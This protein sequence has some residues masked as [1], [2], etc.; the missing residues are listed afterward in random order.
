M[1]KQEMLLSE[2]LKWR[3]FINQTTLENIERLD[4][5]KF[6]FYLG[7]DPSASSMTVGNLSILMMVK[8]FINAGHTCFLLA[9]GATGMIGDPDG[10]KEE[11][12]LLSLN[13]INQNKKNIKNQ[14]KKILEGKKFKL[15]DNFDWFKKI[16]YLDFLREVGKN[17]PMSKMLNREFIKE[18]IADENSG[19]SYAEFSYSLIQGYDF[20]YLNKKFGVNLQIAGSDQWGNCIAGV[21]L[22]RRIN[23]KEADI[24]T[25]PLII[26]KK[27]GKK[28]GK[29]EGGAIWL[30]EK[31]T[32]VYKF[33]QFWL[34][35][36]D[37]GVIDY[38]KIYTLFSK[39]EIENL[40]KDLKENPHLR[41]AQKV[42]ALEIT[43]IV[44]GKEKAEMAKNITEILFSGDF[45]K[46]NKK[47]I[48]VLKK[49][50]SF[51][52]FKK[53]KNKDIDLAQIAL[54]LK[55]VQSKSE[56]R[57]FIEQKGLTLNEVG[58]NNFKIIKKG[59][60]NFGIVEI[61]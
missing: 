29:S 44:H 30:D 17:V 42:L 60:N 32:S 34:N 36:D 5:E 21:D 43:K 3:G 27:T 14:F 9:G 51:V 19:I 58:L 46:L 49:E 55:L 39:N 57:N 7:V 13:D 48:E 54:D 18:R 26:D 22:I 11:R 41:Q 15:V 24:W 50:L 53:E 61:N 35:V 10:K 45:K 40:E 25:A 12:K 56:A 28:F 23:K 38:L 6:S 31:L 4:K 33:Y 16:N 59:K 37:V 1:K 47:E 2:N 8:H 52:K 20:V